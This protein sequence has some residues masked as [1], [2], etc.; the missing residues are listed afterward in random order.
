[1][2]LT[3]LYL[4]STVFCVSLS[5][6]RWRRAMTGWLSIASVIGT[7]RFNTCSTMSRT[8]SPSSTA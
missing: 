1:M 7:S 8:S 3:V 4:T 6:S 2:P 5:P